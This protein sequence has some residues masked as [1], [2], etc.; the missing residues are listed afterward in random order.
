MNILADRILH[1]AHSSDMSK[2]I[3]TSQSYAVE[4]I[5][6]NCLFSVMDTHQN[7]GFQP[8]NDL[9]KTPC[10]PNVIFDSCLLKH[11]LKHLI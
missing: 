9:G 2:K 11:L 7:Q 8:H 6:I 5:D 10:T 3:C 4:R 1:I